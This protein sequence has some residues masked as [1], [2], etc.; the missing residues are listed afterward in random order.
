MV[1]KK[2]KLGPSSR[3]KGPNGAGASFGCSKASWE[4]D[5]IFVLGFGGGCGCI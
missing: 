1:R 2:E 3:V 4:E 5:F